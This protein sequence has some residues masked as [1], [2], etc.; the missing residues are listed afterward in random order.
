MEEFSTPKDV[1]KFL[2]I[3]K[4]TLYRLVK[5]GKIPAIKIGKQLR[6]S[7]GRLLTLRFN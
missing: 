3:H 2:K 1:V 5:E 6:F 4:V 7:K